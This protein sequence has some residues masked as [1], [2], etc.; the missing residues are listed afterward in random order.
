MIVGDDGDAFAVENERDQTLNDVDRNR[1]QRYSFVPPIPSMDTHLNAV[2]SSGA[3]L[4]SGLYPRSRE[5][6]VGQFS[7]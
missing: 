5:L 3:R 6:N 1:K 2:A 7:P 4:S